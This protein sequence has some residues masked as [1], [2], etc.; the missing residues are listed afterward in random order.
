M[1]RKLSAIPLLLLLLADL[2]LAARDQRGHIEI[3]HPLANSVVR[4]QSVEIE[5][6]ISGLQVPREGYGLVQIDDRTVRFCCA[7]VHIFSCAECN[8]S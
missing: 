2:V 6:L 5:V 3:L 1:Q 7:A 4:R 8:R